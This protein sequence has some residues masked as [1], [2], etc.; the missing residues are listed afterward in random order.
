MELI[1]FLRALWQFALVLDLTALLFK[2][3]VLK[4]TS[5]RLLS[6]VVDNACLKHVRVPM[7]CSLAATV[8]L[9]VLLLLVLALVLTEPLFL[10]E[11]PRRTTKPVLYRVAA[12]AHPNCESAIMAPYQAALLLA[13][14]Q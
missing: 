12:L 7:V 4:F 13:L 3:A 10:M 2:V 8:L 11:Q 6:R 14:A 5:N 1:N 9:P